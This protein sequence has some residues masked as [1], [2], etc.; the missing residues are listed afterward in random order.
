MRC[1]RCNFENE[2]D[3]Q[4]CEECGSKFALACPGCGR[5]VRPTAK[6]CRQCGTSLSVPATVNPQ[7]P[8]PVTL[9]TTT[10]PRTEPRSPEAERRQ[11]TV[12]F[13]DLVGSTALSAQ[14]DP[15]EL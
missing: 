2:P 6:F 15:E 1:S 13:C 5:E 7:R 14:L 8:S 10:Q 9:A 11:L 12:M 3:A 4:F